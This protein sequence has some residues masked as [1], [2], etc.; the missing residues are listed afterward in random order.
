MATLPD[1]RTQ[2]SGKKAGQ[3]GMAAVASEVRGF[4]AKQSVVSNLNQI[5][6]LGYLPNAQ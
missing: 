2:T 5:S 3:D 1:I 6:L 4:M